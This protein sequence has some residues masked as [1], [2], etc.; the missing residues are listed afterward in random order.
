MAK[1]SELYYYSHLATGWLPDSTIL[2]ERVRNKI[3]IPGR[4]LVRDMKCTEL[5][6]VLSKKKKC[7]EVTHNHQIRKT[8]TRFRL[9]ISQILTYKCRHMDEIL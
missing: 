8:F 1:R 6:E 9:R 4:N 3:G 7:L 5:S 2:L